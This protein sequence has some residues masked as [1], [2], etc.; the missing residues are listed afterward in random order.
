M[1]VRK[2]AGKEIKIAALAEL[3]LAKKDVGAS[4]S[5]TRIDRLFL[6]P[7]TKEAEIL[8]GS[9]DEVATRLAQIMKDKGS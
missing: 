6:P 5:M 8:Q 4:G 9:P 1:G 3:G 2:A 7:V